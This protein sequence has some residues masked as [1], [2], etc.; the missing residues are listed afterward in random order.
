MTSLPATPHERCFSSTETCLRFARDRD[1]A[2]SLVV[3]ER[4]MILA[5]GGGGGLAA[6]APSRQRRRR[7][8]ARGSSFDDLAARD[9]A[10]TLFLVDGDL[11][12]VCPRPRLRVIAGSE[13]TDDDPRSR[14]RRRSCR[15]GA[16]PATPPTPPR[17][18]IIL[19]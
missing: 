14:R 6:S 17:E 2:S 5:H 13:G 4:M 10:Q 11:S 7:R 16:E 3:R 9:A 8:R 19:R 18:R 12:P 15:V 1:C